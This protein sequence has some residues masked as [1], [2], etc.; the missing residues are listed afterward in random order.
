[1]I[2]T[3]P[4]LILCLAGCVS[5]RDTG[6][7]AASS[8]DAAFHRAADEFIAGYL[9]WRPDTGTS[10]GLHEYDGRVTDFRS[11]SLSA[12]LARLKRFDRTLSEMQTAS[13]SKNAR[14]DL[15]IL[16][17]AINGELFKF[18]DLESY[19]S[20]PMTY[21]GAIDLNIYVKRDFAPLDRR[22]KS[23]IAIEN[24]SGQ[25]FAAARANL[26]ASLPKPFVETAIEIA[27]GSADFL[28]N[29][30]VI[31]LREVKNE[32]LMTE[33]KAANAK[34]VAELRAYAEW[35]KTEKLPKADANYAI[36][37]E[38]FQKMLRGG[39]LIDLTP[40]QILELGLK[41]LRR[42]QQVFA[43]TAKKIDPTKDPVEVYRAIQREHPTAD[44]LI[45][46]TRKTLEAIRQFV[47]DRRIVVIPSEVRVL[48]EETP[49][50]RRATSFASM[51]T[52]GPFETKATQ[53]YYYVTPT[54]KDWSPEKKDEW[55]TSFNF[56]TTDVVS[57]HEAY[58]GHYTQALW[59]NASDATRTEKIFSSYAFVE[60]W[61]H[62]C[63]QMA[64]D[65]GFG[66]PASGNPTPAE[67]ITAAKYRLAQS[68]EA[69]LRL[70]RLC[71]S[72]QMHCQG[73][74]LSDATKFFED[75]CHYEHKPAYQEALRGTFDPG[76]L[77]Y[78]LGKLQILKLRS[79]YRE[80]EGA[81]FSLRK[82][83]D[84]TLQHGMPPIRLLREVLLKNSKTW[85][86]IL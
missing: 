30:L 84:A 9:A 22:V 70:C 39:E 80:Q 63:E 32:A 55:L 85:N 44:N 40:E 35:L 27:N 25:I 26:N 48:V 19:S 65:E 74:S 79:D 71:V 49:Q 16:Q 14:Y 58:P 8:G 59:L 78:T 7:S 72:I 13:L 23:I 17:T 3:W 45:P 38:K 66:L 54:E 83:H 81:T 2:R 76:Y 6:P 5:S 33:F 64:L 1:M 47:V 77:Y 57:I 29:D 18:E 12:E 21:A 46:D 56:F 67:S 43:D 24:Q 10:L 82:F 52:P 51:D 31:A 61:A 34:T 15:R 68:D 28:S 60:G 86:D 62:Y 73:M 37:R 36:G 50:Y 20:N 11:A 69:L 4:L 41:E 75:N 53:A 42:E